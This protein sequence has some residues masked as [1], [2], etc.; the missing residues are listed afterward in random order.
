MTPLHDPGCNCPPAF[1]HEDVNKDERPAEDL[2]G[3]HLALA[4]LHTIYSRRLYRTVFAITRNSHDAEDAL[5]DTFLRAHLAL[6]TFQGRSDVYSWLT[7]IAINSAL[8]IL[9]RRRSRPEV[10]FDPEPDTTAEPVLIEIRDSAPDPEEAYVRRL[11]QIVLFRAIR[12]LS[13]HLRKP[14]QMRME[15]DS[16]IKEISRALK[17]SEAAAKTRLHRA[18]LKLSSSCRGFEGRF[19][20]SRKGQQRTTSP[21]KGQTI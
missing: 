7:R 16:S 14:L 4:D 6:H 11:R 8:M 18:R 2:R 20:N 10:L 12:S 21:R 17:I 9:R 1:E 13:D 5:Q 15:S 3:S 19:P